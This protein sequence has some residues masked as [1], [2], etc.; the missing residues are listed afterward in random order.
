MYWFS[1][2]FSRN[3]LGFE[4]YSSDENFLAAIQLVGC[5]NILRAIREDNLN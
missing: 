5:K 3:N 2:Y 1:W 4:E